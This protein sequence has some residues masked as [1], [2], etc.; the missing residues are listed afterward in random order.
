VQDVEQLVLNNLPRR[1]GDTVLAKAVG[2]KVGELHR[3]F[4]DVRSATMYQALYK[5]RLETVK[6]ILESDPTRAPEAVA[7]E[8]G[9]GHYGVFHRRYRRYLELREQEGHAARA[10]ADGAPLPAVQASA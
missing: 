4:L 10:E 5:L 7:F 8:C 1:L 3:A 6:C 9:F 2:V